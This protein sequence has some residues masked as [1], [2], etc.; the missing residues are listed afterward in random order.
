[1][2]VEEVGIVDLH[3]IVPS[4]VQVRDRGDLQGMADV[5]GDQIFA[6]LCER[7]RS[8]LVDRCR[9]S[10]RPLRRILTAGQPPNGQR[11]SGRSRAKD[12]EKLIT[13]QLHVISCRITGVAVRPSYR[14]GRR[15][16]R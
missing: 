14:T 8:R 1:M 9:L 5:V 15:S 7:Q 13:G 16:R 10:R 12:R 3:R 11:H 6:A 2:R 4:H